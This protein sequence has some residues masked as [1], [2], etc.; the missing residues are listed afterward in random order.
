MEPTATRYVRYSFTCPKNHVNRREGM[1]FAGAPN[2]AVEA[3][4]RQS[5]E[6]DTCG[7]TVPEGTGLTVERN[8]DMPS[9]SEDTF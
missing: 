4:R 3:I 2:E 1:V 8:D 6:C 9:V 7:V 5:L